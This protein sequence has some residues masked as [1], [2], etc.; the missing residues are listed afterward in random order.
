MIWILKRPSEAKIKKEITVETIES[1]IQQQQ[2]QQQQ[3]H[4]KFESKEWKHKTFT[5]V[6]LCNIIIIIII[7]FIMEHQ[8]VDV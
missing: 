4:R 6:L 7:I 5:N 3:H 2:Q 1:N 8:P